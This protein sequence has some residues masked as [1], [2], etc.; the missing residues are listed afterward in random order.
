MSRKLGLVAF[1]FAFLLFL[2]PRNLFA[3]RAP[4]PASPQPQ[5]ATGQP[6]TIQTIDENDRVTLTGNTRPEA[7]PENDRGK[8]AGQFPMQHMLLQLKRTPEQEEALKQFID[9]LHTNG[10]TQFHN[11]TSAQEFAARFGVARQD[12]EA[13]IRWLERHGFTVNVDYPSGMLIDFSGTA[14]QVQAAF[15]TEIHELD[16]RGER[17]FA[18][19][20]DPQIPRAL[21][22]V[23]AGVVSMNDFRPRTMHRLRTAEFSFPDGFGGNTN[24][25]VPADLATIYNVNPVFNSGITGKGQTIVLIEDT[26][27]FTPADWTTFRNTFGLA[28][29]TSASFTSVHPAPA[30]GANNCGNPGIV[31][32]N[33]AEAILDAEWASAA[34]PDAAIVMASCAD[35]S[36]TFGGLIAI[37][38]LINSSQ[39]PAI[40]SISYGQC[41][42]VNG[43]AANAAY[44]SA[45]QQAVAEGASIFVAAGDSGAAGCDNS[46]TEATHGIA[47]NAFASTPYNVAVGGTDFSD[48]YS[49]TDSVY[50]N[51][52]NTAAFGSAISYIPEMPWDDSCAGGVLSAYEVMPSYGPSSLCSDPTFGSLL[53]TTVAGG[54]GPSACATGA[55]STPDVVSGSCQGWPKPAWQ[56]VL[57]NP[58]DGVRDTPDISLFAADGL[59]GHYYVFC[60]SD[61]AN[62]GAACS[63]DPSGWSGA[64]GTSFA[65]PIMAGVQALVNQKQGAPQGNP[66]PVYYQLANLEY[67]GSGS[68]ACD[69]SNGATVGASCVFY[70]V[71]FGDMD[72]DC[73]GSANCYFGGGTVG[74]LSTSNNAFAPA[75]GTNT[76]WDFATGIGTVNVANLVNSWVGSGPSFFL[77]ASPNSLSIVPGTT[78]TSTI[79]VIPQ[80]GFNGSVSLSASGLPNG[81]SASFTPTATSSTSTLT[82][83]VSSSAPASTANV[84][85]TGTSGNLISTA[86]V[87]LTVATPTFT[88]SASPTTLS[89]AQA[90]SGTSTI[91]VGPQN[92]FSGSVSFSASGL[93]NG[94]TASFNPGTTSSSSTLTLTVSSA[95][96]VGTVNVTITGTSGSLIRATTVSLTVT[97]MPTF[98]LS[99][100]PASLTIR[101]G[102]TGT[103]TITVV[104]QNGFNGSVSLSA[105]G[106][107]S[108]VTASFNPGSTTG[109]STLTLSATGTAAPGIV[110][111]NINGTSGSLSNATSISLTVKAVTLPNGWTDDDVGAVGAAGDASYANGTF[112]IKAAG[113]WING[114]ADAMHW[115]YQP[116]SGDG[117]LVA[118]LISFQGGSTYASAGVMIR[119]T[120][121]SGSRNAITA[122]WPGYNGIFFDQRTTPA[123]GT[124]QLANVSLPALPYWVKLVRAGNSFSSYAALDGVNWVQI[125]TTQ[126]ITMASNVYLGLAVSSGS[127]SGLATAT[128]DNVSITSATAPAPSI[129]TV[130]ATTGSIGSS[131]NITGFNFG[132]TQGN[133]S[134][135]LNGAPLTINSW[136]DSSIS[137]TLPVGATSGALAVSVAPAMNVSN[138]V[139]FT[140]TAQPLPSGW[141]DQDVGALGVMGSASYNNGVFTVKAVGRQISGTADSMHLVYQPLTGDGTM[142]ARVVSMQGSVGFATAGVMIR[143]TLDSGAR[144]AKTAHWPY[145][146]YIYF[147]LRTTPG[148]STSEPGGWSAALPYWVKLVR[149]GNTFSSYASS[150]GSHWTQIGSSQTLAMTATVY[151][152]LAANS[153]SNSTLATATFDNVTITTP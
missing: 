6:S 95:A 11:W 25:L 89:I 69:A 129:S 136:S 81:V 62:G 52:T 113:P 125:S 12:R 127:S 7:R 141:L 114:T 88:L 39:P 45:Y 138:P 148:G 54:G 97:P 66:N 5:T 135:L 47:V 22:S 42:T 96:Q 38:N 104:P 18:N 111:I 119:E 101:Q 100:Q 17:H 37:E 131:A 99:A 137:A 72:V 102:G 14:D 19:V 116:L 80:N 41:E 23:V 109:A 118:R 16:V 67:G 63:G 152:G 65:A 46:V 56:S 126:T 34:A 133:S 44:N 64:G 140:V 143:E 144:N 149:S 108:G 73:A 2:S 30:H 124:S 32:P 35:T 117:S 145:Y 9:E 10:S 58:S 92:G 77:S 43:A 20:R 79:S 3:H 122:V 82:F 36:T 128:F 51:S 103:S 70:D 110:T 55:P 84:V 107:P 76:G 75:Y 83:S 153:G 121:D 26:N 57:G 112:T 150:D 13:I 31:A 98:G 60:W 94:V 132:S 90:T 29:Y 28:A 68:S 87:T 48:T 21:T 27:V 15:N 85:I 91:S 74:V 71:T 40:I 105:S 123:G 146:N 1:L 49:G 8:V 59:W 115:A 106:L 139:T 151:I 93:P 78:G 147:D 53:A 142:V 130:S 24:A 61:T 50:W 86:S 134:V 120:L 4:E 33:D